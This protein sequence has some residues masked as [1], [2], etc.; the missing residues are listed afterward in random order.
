MIP[1]TNGDWKQVRRLLDELTPAERAALPRNLDLWWDGAL[2]CGGAD[3]PHC[4][5]GH[6]SLI[7]HGDP[8]VLRKDPLLYCWATFFDR[9][10][11]DYG[12]ET[13]VS[14]ILAYVTPAEPAALPG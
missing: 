4:L 13:T 11:R 2:G 1:E 5:I 9:L 10:C 8:Y 12:L 14:A 7:R 6:L 3:E